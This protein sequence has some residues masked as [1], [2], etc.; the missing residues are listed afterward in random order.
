M[1]AK[2]LAERDG[3]EVRTW[4]AGVGPVPGRFMVTWSV[5]PY[6]ADEFVSP[7]AKD[8]TVESTVTLALGPGGRKHVLE[9][10]GSEETPTAAVRVFCPPG[11]TG[12]R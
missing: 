2:R 8:T 1:T 12:G 10:A 6:F 5:I 9:I 11:M 7:G 4:L 3:G